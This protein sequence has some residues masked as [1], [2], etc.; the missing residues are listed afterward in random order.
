MPISKPKGK[1]G[2]GAKA[3]TPNMTTKPKPL[4]TKDVTHPKPVGRPTKYE[5]RYCDEAEAFMAQGYSLGAFAGSIGVARSTINEW[6]DN[7]PDFSEAVSRAKAKRLMHWETAGLA[8]AKDGGGPGTATIIVFGLKNMGDADWS[9]RQ[10]HEL[11]GP[12]G[13]PIETKTTVDLSRLNPDQ[14]RALA[15]IKLPTDT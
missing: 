14:L 2:A 7:Q 3:K 6:I 10:Q 4:K 11:S 8:V 9:D 1:G 13:A 5:P 15:S 12:G